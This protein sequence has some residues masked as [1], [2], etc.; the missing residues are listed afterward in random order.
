MIVL[1]VNSKGVFVLRKADP[2]IRVHD[3]EYC[4]VVHNCLRYN[5]I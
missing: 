1:M 2:G 5:I 3:T 4:Q